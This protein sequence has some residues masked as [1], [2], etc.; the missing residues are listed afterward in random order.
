M[1][2]STIVILN[3]LNIKIIKSIKIILKK[4]I[5]ENTI[6]IHSILKKKNYED[7]FSSSSL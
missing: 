4:I 6:A 3:Q 5:W 7:K 1:R 2:K